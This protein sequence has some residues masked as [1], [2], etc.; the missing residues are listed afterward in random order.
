MASLPRAHGTMPSAPE[1]VSRT[2]EPRRA[3]LA[4]GR[5]ALPAALPCGDL[6]CSREIWAHG[7]HSGFVTPLD[8]HEPPAEVEPIPEL[9]DAFAQA[10]AVCRGAETHGMGPLGRA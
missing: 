3:H 6:F 9:M 4:V 5:R 8:T 7:P 10:S 2:V 1:H